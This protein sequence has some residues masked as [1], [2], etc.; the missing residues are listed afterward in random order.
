MAL[1]MRPSLTWVV[2]DNEAG[3]AEGWGEAMK[4]GEAMKDGEGNEGWGGGQ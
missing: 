2:W 1:G 3:P 4:G